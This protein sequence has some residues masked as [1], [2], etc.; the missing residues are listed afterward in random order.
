MYKKMH[1]GGSTFLE[2]ETTEAWL[3]GLFCGESGLLD[4][5]MK[6]LEP[7]VKAILNGY[8]LFGKPGMINPRTAFGGP[9]TDDIFVIG[10]IYLLLIFIIPYNTKS[11]RNDIKDSCFGSP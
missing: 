7:F 6:G 8:T 1:L 2:N 5:R 10:L 9:L 3:S 4:D 11:F